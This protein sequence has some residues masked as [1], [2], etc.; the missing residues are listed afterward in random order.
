MNIFKTK[1]TLYDPQFDSTSRWDRV[2]PVLGPEPQLYRKTKF[3][4]N[5]S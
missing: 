3:L 2:L 1:P 5:L 4:A